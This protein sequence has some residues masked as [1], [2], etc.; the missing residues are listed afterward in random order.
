[1]RSFQIFIPILSSVSG[2]LYYWQKFNLD[3]LGM[4]SRPQKNPES[5]RYN[6]K[7]RKSEFSQ[8]HLQ[9]R[10]TYIKEVQTFQDI[11]LKPCQSLS[12]SVSVKTVCGEVKF[13][14]GFGIPR[15]IH[16]LSSHS[17]Q[18]FPSLWSLC[19]LSYF[20]LKWQLT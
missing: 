13:K 16:K 12:V 20:P 15:C 19:Y 2:F 3:H 14:N 17:M 7:N 18:I 6:L 11:S 4:D 9:L 10:M 5:P 1:M 8:L